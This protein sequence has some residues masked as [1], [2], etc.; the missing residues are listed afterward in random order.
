MKTNVVIVVPNWNG[1]DYIVACL[2]SL[3]A[4]TAK[5]HIVVVDNGSSDGSVKLIQEK[6]PGV[7]IIELE[8]N[9]G[10]TGGVN[11]GI[12]L[13][14]ERGCKYAALF[15][16]DAVA[17]TSWLQKLAATAN[18]HSKTGIVSCKLM[19]DDKKHI[20]STGE[21]YSVWGM[22]FPRGRNEIDNGQYDDQN[23]IFAASGGASLYR[24]SM[25]EEIGLFDED[26]FAYFEDVDISFR[27]QLAG[28]KVRYEP[29]AVA[30]HQG[31]A[32]SSKLAGFARYHSVK[33]FALLY[34]KNMPWRLYFKYA[35]LVKFWFIRWLFASVLRGHLLTFLKSWLVAIIL[36]PKAFKKRRQIQSSRKVSVK[37]IDSMLYHHRP[38]RPPKLESK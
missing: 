32:T 8:K 30:Y 33:N 7:E 29:S 15:N 23:E 16:N 22:P 36:T 19:R 4:Q 18:N 34:M 5:A 37:Y 13:A 38:P 12:K 2:R 21:L 9:Y 25:L 24:V 20:D 6:F 10:F 31:G 17:E 14:I 26:F 28:W 11:K 27:A 1:A 35:L 3:E